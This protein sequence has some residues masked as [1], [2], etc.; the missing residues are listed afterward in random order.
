[1]DN[2]L[3]GRDDVRTCTK[4]SDWWSP[5]HT[6]VYARRDI[7][8]Y[9]IRPGEVDSTSPFPSVE[10]SFEIIENSLRLLQ[11]WYDVSMAEL[12]TGKNKAAK[13]IKRRQPN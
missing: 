5:N 6:N 11:K 12:T 2:V 4:C 9:P 1:M 7:T 3:S 10:L 13:L 8:E